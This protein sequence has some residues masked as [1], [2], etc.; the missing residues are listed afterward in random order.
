MAIQNTTIDPLDFIDYCGEPC[1]IATLTGWLDEVCEC[2]GRR[3]GYDATPENVC[4]HRHVEGVV[5]RRLI[6]EKV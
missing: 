5:W 1:G 6:D 3:W 4:R 2:C